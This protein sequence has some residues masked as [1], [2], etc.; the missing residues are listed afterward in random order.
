MINQLFT[1]HPNFKLIIACLES[2]GFKRGLYDKSEVLK[3]NLEKLNIPFKF[4]TFKTDFKNI[5]I[6]CKYNSIF[7]DK[8]TVK[9]CITI[10]KQILKTINYDLLSKEKTINN[11]K[12][13]VYSIISI[14]NKNKSNDT[15]NKKQRKKNKKKTNTNIILLG[16]ATISFM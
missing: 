16:P 7:K 5:Y 4:E 1:K 12:E 2:I 10:T 3:S 13:T 6:S 9:K 8:L 14:Q 15:I 11:K